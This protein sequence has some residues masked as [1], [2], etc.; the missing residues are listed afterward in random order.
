MFWGHVLEVFANG[1]CVLAVQNTTPELL[2]IGP[3]LSVCL[4]VLFVH[5]FFCSHFL[6]DFCEEFICFFTKKSLKKGDLE[7]I[8]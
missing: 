5:T 3:I 6:D 1:I 7:P 4:S 2:R 8:T